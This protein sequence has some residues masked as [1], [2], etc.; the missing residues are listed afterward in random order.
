MKSHAPVPEGLS[1]RIAT[2][3]T[4]LSADSQVAALK[5]G[6]SLLGLAKPAVRLPLVEL[7]YDARKAVAL[8]MTAFCEDKVA[9]DA[10]SRR[11]A[12]S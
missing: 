5:Y 11:L 12:K 6:L 1:A 7:G 9:A 8:A 4:V 2:L 3:A 10:S